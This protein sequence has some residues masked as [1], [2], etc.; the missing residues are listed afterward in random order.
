MALS[1]IPKSNPQR[2]PSRRRILQG[3][4]ATI[5]T[6][7]TAVAYNTHIPDAE[8]VQAEPIMP[9]PVN[10]ETN[11]YQTLRDI[12]Q[13]E[14]FS[15]PNHTAQRF[16]A[17]IDIFDQ[18]TRKRKEI[19][20]YYTL[21][22]EIVFEAAKPENWHAKTEDEK[23]KWHNQNRLNSDARQLHTPSS[24]AASGYPLVGVPYFVKKVKDQ[25]QE[26]DAVKELNERLN[27]E[28]QDSRYFDGKNTSLRDAIR[29]LTKAYNVPY[30]IAIGLAAYES[31]F[32]KKEKSKKKAQGIFQFLKKTSDD[33][34]KR[35]LRDTEHRAGGI[36]TFKKEITNNFAQT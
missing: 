33:D 34:A 35:Y 24:Y 27:K 21:D 18:F 30:A 32:R 36:G 2:G 29:K 7:S 31:G 23:Q 25:L 22:G 12:F 13:E 28:H 14:T 5:A 19:F 9:E 8:P 16:E 3:L 17:L 6:V 15:G 1:E 11:P 4:L 26:A 10:V 20:S